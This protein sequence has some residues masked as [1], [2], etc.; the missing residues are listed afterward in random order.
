MNQFRVGRSTVREALFTLQRKGLLTARPGAAARVS[1][2]DADT[3]VSELTGAARHLLSQPH[4]VRQLQNAR[5]LFEIGLAR[6]AAQHATG[7]DIEKLRLA[8]EAN[9]TADDQPTFER[10][11]LAFHYTLAMIANNSIF[12]SLHNALMAW[13]AEQRSVSARAGA[14]RSEIFEQHRA[15]FEAIEA[16]D[17]SAAENAMESHLATVA[18]Y[19]WL[20]MSPSARI[21]PAGVRPTP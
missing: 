7:E 10:T 9:R 8:L 12:A 3:L 6:H 21:E 18:R 14:T 19:Y 13:L 5:A 11:D 1:R 2:P 20:A 17:V 15:I 16:G 4:G